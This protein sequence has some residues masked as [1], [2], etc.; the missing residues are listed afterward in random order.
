M[1]IL[2]IV[3]ALCDSEKNRMLL[4][5]QKA[6]LLKIAVSENETI[7]YSSYQNTMYKSL[8]PTLL[9]IIKDFQRHELQHT[10]MPVSF[11]PS[12]KLPVLESSLSVGHSQIL[13]SPFGFIKDVHFSSTKDNGRV[14]APTPTDSVL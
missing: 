6:R 10:N 4:W 7:K 3:I 8:H 5:A 9:K 12:V 14:Y 1:L 2:Q 11:S 13:S